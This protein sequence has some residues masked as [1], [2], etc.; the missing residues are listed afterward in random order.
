MTRVRWRR[1]EPDAW[2]ARCG[3]LALLVWW[4]AEC[5]WWTW[6]VVRGSWAR[7]DGYYDHTRPAPQ[8]WSDVASAGEE[9]A[10]RDGLRALARAVGA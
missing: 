8:K 5:E 6:T 9:A 10:I 7:W 4:D 1:P 3:A 2:E